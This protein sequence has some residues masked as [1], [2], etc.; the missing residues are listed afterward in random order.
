[1]W[2]YFE[3]SFKLYNFASLDTLRS[4]LVSIAVIRMKVGS[5]RKNYLE[6]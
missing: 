3:I 5:K 1:M 4:S 2:A 6:I